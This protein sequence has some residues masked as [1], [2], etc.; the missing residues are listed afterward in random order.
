M[1]YNCCLAKTIYD[2]LI[3]TILACWHLYI[4]HS[5]GITNFELKFQTI[6]AAWVSKLVQSDNV[7]NKLMNSCII[8]DMI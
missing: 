1:G 4:T 2:Q 7:L 3:I 8:D 5:I 6:K